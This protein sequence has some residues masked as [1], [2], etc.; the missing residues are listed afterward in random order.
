MLKPKVSV[1]IINFN[2][3]KYIFKCLEH[4]RAQTYP[5]IEVMVVDNVSTDGSSEKLKEMALSNEILYHRAASNGGSSKANNYGI[6]HTSGEYVLILN[7]DAFLNPEHIERSVAA[8]LSDPEIGTVVG[9]LV[10]SHDN[11]FIDSTGVLLFR[12]GIAL[13]RGQRE[14]DVG[15]YDRP[16]FMAAACCAAALYSRRM[17]EA[18]R[19]GDEYY[20]ED[21]FA[22][23]E[24]VDLSVRALLLGW[25]TLY[26]PDAVAQHVR[27]A[28][29][30]Q[31]SRM[32]NLLGRKNLRLFYFKT[33][34]HGD[35]LGAAL[36]QLL[37]FGWRFAAT[38]A[39]EREFR[40]EIATGLAKVRES[41]LEKRRRLILS[42]NY[43]RLRPFCSE[44]YIFRRLKSVMG[45]S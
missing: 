6:R 9:K 14:K 33:F 35:W 23:Y 40:E 19:L 12:E 8:F 25:K 44:S 4:V 13:D 29:N 39:L 7:A 36:R 31:G 43:D 42:A 28:S 30:E 18:V 20:D 45:H 38:G 22:F 41:Y 1:V 2:S 26:T 21:F 3:G 10:S 24:D 32:G 27:G 11:S 15:Q 5:N 17:L 16:M 37:Y 34:E